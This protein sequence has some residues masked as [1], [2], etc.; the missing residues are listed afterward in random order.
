VDHYAVP[1]DI[2]TPPTEGMGISWEVVGSARPKNLKK[3]MKPNWNFQRGGGSY[4]KIPS[5]GEVLELHIRQTC[6]LYK[7]S[8]ETLPRT[9]TRTDLVAERQFP[10]E[11]SLSDI[12]NPDEQ[13]QETLN[14]FVK[15]YQ[16]F[17]SKDMRVDRVKKWNM[18]FYVQKVPG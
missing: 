12:Q 8:V 14:S 3:C 1:E 4:K 13:K 7:K 18:F 16:E 15:F 17:H 2:H 5:V 6:N 11:S 9:G 10:F